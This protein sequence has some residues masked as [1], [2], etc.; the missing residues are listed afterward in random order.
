MT[1]NIVLNFSAYTLV[2][3]KE[4]KVNDVTPV[5]TSSD[6]PVM[7]LDCANKEDVSEKLKD[8]ITVLCHGNMMVKNWKDSVKT[9]SSALIKSIP[10]WYKDPSIIT[11]VKLNFVESDTEK[12][13][14]FTSEYSV[15]LSFTGKEKKLDNV[16]IDAN[17][18]DV[19]TRY[20][21]AEKKST[22]ESPAKV[23]KLSI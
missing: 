23:S 17:T 13:G 3:N 4:T 16:L 20:E 11:S 6:S 15:T 8:I 12:T 5:L 1:T 14:K 19:L 7:V 22:T 2:A 21:S 18:F 9:F 10:A